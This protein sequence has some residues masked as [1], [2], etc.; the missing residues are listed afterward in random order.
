MYYEKYIGQGL[1][2]PPIIINGIDDPT[3]ATTPEAPTQEGKNTGTS[4]VLTREGEDH[5]KLDNTTI[6]AN[7]E[8]AR[9]AL[10]RTIKPPE[11]L[12]QEIGAIAA[13]GAT[14]AANYEIALTA[15]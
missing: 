6:P 4:S 8:T 13:A 11:H 12:I 5:D 15:S 3:P 9:T 7:V 1:I 2:V 14:A 10:G